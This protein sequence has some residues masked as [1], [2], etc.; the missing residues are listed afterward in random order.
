MARV[1]IPDEKREIREPA[2]MKAFLKQFGINFEQWD[3]AGGLVPRQ[4]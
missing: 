4:Q 2:E 1:Q 3:V